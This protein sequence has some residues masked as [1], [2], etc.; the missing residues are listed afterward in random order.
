MR[1]T[2]LLVLLV[3]TLLLLAA[4]WW[5]AQSKAHSFAEAVLGGDP[6]TVASAS[7]WWE[8]DE[9][10][11]LRQSWVGRSSTVSD[12]TLV[13]GSV[14]KIFPPVLTLRFAAQS[15]TGDQV[16]R[17]LAVITRLT[18]DGWQIHA[19]GVDGAPQDQST[20]P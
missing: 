12:A 10:V 18:G 3:A 6:G 11:S 17:Q 20:S 15:Q 4:A 14:T 1:R 9:L 19:F 2:T 16:G 8:P 13:S 5:G 7:G